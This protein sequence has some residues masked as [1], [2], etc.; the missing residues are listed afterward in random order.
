MPS[1]SSSVQEASSLNSVKTNISDVTLNSD[2][3][4][5]PKSNSRSLSTTL[6]KNVNNLS[7]IND[8]VSIK[9]EVAPPSSAQSIS[10]IKKVV[11]PPDKQKPNSI[12]K[13]EM[14]IEDYKTLT[15][16]NNPLTLQMLQETLDNFRYDI[17]KELQGI[18]REQ[19]RQFAMVKVKISFSLTYV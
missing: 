4:L 12:D 2:I 11:G 10:V 5:S 15:D 8:H 16:S 3:S 6:T 18:I 17:H 7:D 13:V 19:A 9:S 14:S 1:S